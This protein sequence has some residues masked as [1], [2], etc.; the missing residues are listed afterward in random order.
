MEV[1]DLLGVYHNSLSYSPSASPA[2]K[3]EPVFSVG[4]TPQALSSQNLL[5][6]ITVAVL[7]RELC[8]D[9]KT[10]INSL[11]NSTKSN[12]TVHNFPL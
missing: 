3:E 8:L 11:N 2:D 5:H 1:A 10:R 12:S 4:A 7:V 9:E 6:D